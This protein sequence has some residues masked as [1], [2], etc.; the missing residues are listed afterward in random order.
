MEQPPSP[1][2]DRLAK[3]Q[4]D[5]TARQDQERRDAS[6]ARP[7]LQRREELYA[8]AGPSFEEIAHQLLD[9]VGRDAPSVEVHL[10]PAPPVGSWTV[11]FMGASMSFGPPAFWPKAPWGD[12]P[13]PAFDVI[14]CSSV[15]ACLPPNRSWG[16]HLGYAGRG[17]SLYF[18]DAQTA[19]TYAWFETAFTQRP[20]PTQR[21]WT[22]PCAR[23]P[24]PGVARALCAGAADD[25]VAWPFTQL[26]PGQL[27]D[28]VDRWVGWFADA[29]EGRLA[30]PSRMP[31][32]P[33]DGTWRRS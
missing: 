19:G 11:T 32:R 7:E 3:V 24:G 1:G 4:R 14:A 2:R 31:E 21:R 9:A 15:C 23:E 22:E 28:F 17:H 25:Q 12:V 8:A 33:V 27:G 13:C 18:C 20:L 30:P 16:Q 26:V 5:H 6:G 10:T 29:I